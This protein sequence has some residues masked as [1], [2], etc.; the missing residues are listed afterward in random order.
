M[1]EIRKDIRWYEWLCSVSNLWRIKM[2]S[3]TVNT[4]RW[5]RTYKEII[6]KVY[7]NNKWYCIFSLPK[8]NGKRKTT[9]IHIV[10][11]RA[12][13]LNPFNKREVNHKDWNKT[14]NYIK[15]LERCTHHENILHY[16]KKLRKHILS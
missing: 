6:L 16:H 5:S 14:N 9:T 11:A 15:N 8:I 1:R 4:S 7:Q 2:L 3:R 13:I 12:F 10:V